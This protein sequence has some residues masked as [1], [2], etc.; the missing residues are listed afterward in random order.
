[1][2]QGR[3]HEYHG[4]AVHPKHLSVWERW[5]GIAKHYNPELDYEQKVKEF[6]AEWEAAMA[7]QV[8]EKTYSIEADDTDET[9]L[10]GQLSKYF[11][12]TS[13][14]DFLKKNEVLDGS[15]EV[16]ATE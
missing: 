9:I 16:S 1:M 14:G 11:Q 6:R 12:R 3:E 7:D 15:N 13:R 2:R 5:T 4:V 8:V 10:H